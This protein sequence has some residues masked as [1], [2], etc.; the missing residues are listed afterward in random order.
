MNL[1]RL[2]YIGT[3]KLGYTEAEVF[4]MTPRKFF[5]IYEE[6]LI[7]NGIKKEKQTPS[8]DNMP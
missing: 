1:A 5:K 4:A 7:L 3:K 6:Y 8:I 2:I